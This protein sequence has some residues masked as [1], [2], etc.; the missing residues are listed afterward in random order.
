MDQPCSPRSVGNG[1]HLRRDGGILSLHF[2][3]LDHRGGH[4]STGYVVSARL[5]SDPGRGVVHGRL[6]RPHHRETSEEHPPSAYGNRKQISG[7]A[8]VSVVAVI[9]AGAW[10]TAL[11]I[12]AGRKGIHEVRLWALEQEVRDSIRERRVN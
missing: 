12:V 9:G 5:S 10:G 8:R 2:T 1:D 11:S 4:V 6:I 3:R 7:E